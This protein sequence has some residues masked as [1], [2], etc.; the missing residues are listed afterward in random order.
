MQCVCCACSL[1]AHGYHGYLVAFSLQKPQGSQGLGC[2]VLSKIAQNLS[3][4][5]SP[6]PGQLLLI[7][8]AGTERRKDAM[9]HSKERQQEGAEINA[10]LHAL[11]D[12]I[13]LI[14]LACFLNMKATRCTT[15]HCYVHFS[16]GGLNCWSAWMI[17]NFTITGVHPTLH[18][19]ELGSFACAQSLLIATWHMDGDPELVVVLMVLC[20]PP[21]F[22]AMTSDHL[23]ARQFP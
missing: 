9:Y 22:S 5:A 1:E 13:Y 19:A 3:G 21:T 14:S 15:L 16:P 18:H 10:S 23:S 6:Q 7:D 12:L 20:Q 8:C 2:P 11:K 17:G 4:T